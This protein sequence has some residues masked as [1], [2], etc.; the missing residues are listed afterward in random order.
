MEETKAVKL[1]NPCDGCGDDDFSGSCI[2][3][4]LLQYNNAKK[5]VEVLQVRIKELE[6]R[7]QQHS[8]SI[9]VYQMEIENHSAE[10]ATLKTNHQEQVKEIFQEL[11][12]RLLPTTLFNNSIWQSFKSKYLSQEK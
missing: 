8:E 7:L 10:I 11:E 9:A 2:C 1:I 12:N 6:E 4:E 5:V 3:R